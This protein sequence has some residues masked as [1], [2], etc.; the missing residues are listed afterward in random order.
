MW[1]CHSLNFL[2]VCSVG[3]TRKPMIISTGMATLEVISDPVRAARSS[4]CRQLMRL[5]C[6]SA[7][8]ASPA[9]LHLHT[10]HDLQRRV[11]YLV[12]L[13]DHALGITTAIAAVT[14]G[15]CVVEKHVTL[16]R[17]K[18]GAETDFSLEAAGPAQLVLETQRPWQYSGKINCGPT[19]QETGFIGI[20]SVVLFFQRH[21][22]G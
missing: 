18:S 20:S 15:V 3:R 6:T 1:G 16:S 10:L 4:G 13:S 21:E 17:A 22:N 14:L 5:K 12:R 19:Q 2:S 11:K 9:E 7:Y 8:P